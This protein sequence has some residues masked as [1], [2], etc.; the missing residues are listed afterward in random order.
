MLTVTQVFYAEDAFMLNVR[1]IANDLGINLSSQLQ[2]L[3]TEARRF[4]TMIYFGGPGSG[5]TILE[6]YLRTVGDL[7]VLP[8]AP[9]DS[10][11]SAFQDVKIARALT[12]VTEAEALDPIL[13]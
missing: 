11:L 6:E 12:T 10:T 2:N 9:T 7:N 4:W 3:S 8:T 1:R 5:N 13:R